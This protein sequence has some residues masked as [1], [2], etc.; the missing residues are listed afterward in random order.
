MKHD[1]ALLGGPSDGTTCT[2]KDPLADTLA[3]VEKT[4]NGA[5]QTVDYYLVEHPLTRR[6]VYA[7]PRVHARLIHG[8]TDDTEETE[9]KSTED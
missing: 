7:H 1:I 2:F 5:D 4:E 6:K 9:E 3:V 8:Q